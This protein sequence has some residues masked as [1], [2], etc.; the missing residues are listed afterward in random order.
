MLQRSGFL[1]EEYR[2]KC[3]QAAREPIQQ[4][5]PS[6]KSGI[7]SMVY[8]GGPSRGLRFHPVVPLPL[9]LPS[10]PTPNYTSSFV[11]SNMI[12]RHGGASQSGRYDEDPVYVTERLE[13]SKGWGV[14]AVR[15]I[16]VGTQL[17]EYTGTDF[18]GDKARE[19]EQA[20]SPST[21]W[22]EI[23]P[24][25]FRKGD[26]RGASLINHACGKTINCPANVQYQRV[27]GST[28][29]VS[30]KPID[31]PTADGIAT[32]LA[33]DYNLDKSHPDNADL[34]WLH[35]LCQ[36][37]QPVVVGVVMPRRPAPVL[38]PDG[39]SNATTTT[40]A[41]TTE[42]SAFGA[43]VTNL[44]EEPR[45]SGA[46]STSN[47]CSTATTTEESAFGADVTNLVEEPRVSGAQSTSNNCSTTTTT[48]EEMERAFN[49][50][51]DV[52]TELNSNDAF[53]LRI[54]WLIKAK[55]VE[56]ITLW[57]IDNLAQL[58]L[59]DEHQHQLRQPISVLGQSRGQDYED[60]LRQR[61]LFRKLRRQEERIAPSNHDFGCISESSESIRPTP[62]MEMVKRVRME[63]VTEEEVGE[64]F[65]KVP[66]QF[67]GGSSGQDSTEQH[68]HRQSNNTVPS[69]APDF[70][71]GQGGQGR[72]RSW[73][74]VVRNRGHT[75][76]YKRNKNQK[77][78]NQRN[79]H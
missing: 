30:I 64:S 5:L 35:Q 39:I 60:K 44:V 56:A 14:A 43:D 59:N 49:D 17:V 11:V 61:A 28:W 2:E 8:N 69:G 24:G 74:G 6:D 54:R 38:G 20:R 47:N 36:V 48:E 29:A 26:G 19:T 13:D 1:S 40:T 18:V 3:D 68:Q 27:E 32:F 12:T 53:N 76:Q 57:S 72:V 75:L 67:V 21:M 65:S 42:E 51:V 33:V 7:G 34:P 73:G 9:S 25:V 31:G 22:L 62:V 52:N 46:Q 66:S 41:T 10:L 55:K 58:K 50:L 77:Q 78:R 16:E 63:E 70:S 71:H 37:C 79:G 23:R 45:V 15:D 4:R